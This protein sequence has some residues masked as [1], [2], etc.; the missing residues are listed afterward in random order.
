MRRTFGLCLLAG[1]LAYLAEGRGGEAHPDKTAARV[2][3]YRFD[4]FHP[5]D[6]TT[7]PSGLRLDEEPPPTGVTLRDGV[8]VLNESQAGVRLTSRQKFLF[9]T[10]EARMRLRPTGFQY[11]GFMSRAPWGADTLDLMSEPGSWHTMISRDGKGGYAGID[12]KATNDR[13]YVVKIVWQPNRAAIYLDDRLQGEITDAGRIPQLP[14][15]IILDVGKPNVAMEFEW[16]KVTGNTFAR[17]RVIP[18]PR[19]TGGGK[20]ITLK[21]ADWKVVVDPVSGAALEATDLRPTPQ[22][23]T[24]EAARAVDLYIRSFPDGEP[25]R[26]LRP[27]G[28]QP[29]V[30]SGNVFSCRLVPGNGP[31]CGQVEAEFALKLEES[32]LFVGGRFRALSDVGHPL[33]IG[34]GM[35]FR[36]QSWQR[37]LFPRNPWLV[38]H[39]RQESPVRLLFL[40]DP[41]DATVAS[42]TGNWNFFPF[43]ILQGS[44]RY[45]LWGGFDLGRRIVLSPGNFG[46]VPAVTLAPKTWPKGKT[47]ELAFSV[48]SFPRSEKDFPAL[49]RWYLSHCTSSDPLAGDL[50]PVKHWTPR[51]LPAGGGVA[52]PD[53]RISRLN[54]K[55]DPKFFDLACQKM[56][57]F[58]IPNLWLNLQIA[59]DGSHPTSGK[60][61]NEYGLPLSAG[62]L[63]AEVARI[64]KLGLRPCSYT[65]QFIMPE[66]LRAGGAPDKNW[67]AYDSKGQASAWAVFSADSAV[68]GGDFFTKELAARLGTRTLSWTY[69]DYGL[70]AFR[71]WYVGQVTAAVD[72]Y[73]PSGLSWDY[74]W[75]GMEPYVAYSRGNPKTSLPHGIL[76]AQTD[77]AAHLRKKYPQ[78]TIIVN[79]T[80]GS[81]SQLLAN[82]LLLENTDTMSDIDFL[83]GKALGSAMSSMDYFSD[84]DRGRWTRQMMLDL[85]RGCSFGAPFWVLMTPPESQYIA[86]WTKFLDFSGRTTCLPTIADE[87]AVVGIS[88]AAQ[89]SLVG[90][91]WSDGT[92]LMAAFFDRR[93]KGGVGRVTV[94]LKTPQGFS[95][96][97]GV[98]WHITRL[99]WMNAEILA[100]ALPEQNWKIDGFVPGH[101]M[102][103]GPLGAGE[104]VLVENAKRK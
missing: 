54:P 97:E 58:N 45:V 32:R 31:Y 51:V 27:P 55:A 16:I 78:M 53:I 14:M 62:P 70:A 91:V 94:S 100:S 24:P 2:W 60:W 9:G 75:S 39:P 67:I 40:A 52:M 77:I 84:H 47:L 103:S 23:W 35:P 101:I 6:W 18:P 21:S 88:G 69:G 49:L 79:E 64:Q 29:A 95:P 63:K 81:P 41:A 13:W 30:A 104:I 87:D 61:Y 36:P 7:Q 20:T 66:L 50:F 25:V 56:L 33:E 96:A 22:T 82:C 46:S 28:D 92:A 89:K 38:L 5:D 34:L 73:Q 98:P 3:E 65:N 15:P 48:C 8:L 57:Q 74:G 86:T 37:Q 4:A 85:A 17:A 72:Y 71:N 76:R 93:M 83:A 99:D 44:D 43:G 80:G 11:F 90:T 68:A 19:P 42:A 102:L 1:L 12:F 10:L 59:I 26:F